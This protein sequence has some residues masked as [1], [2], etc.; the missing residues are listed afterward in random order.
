MVHRFVA[1]TYF[2]LVL[3]QHQDIKPE[4][5]P[6]YQDLSSQ[7]ATY[8]HICMYIS[9]LYVYIKTIIVDQGKTLPT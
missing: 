4:A 7:P 6:N 1:F 8:Q 5:M 9:R 2:V 3:L